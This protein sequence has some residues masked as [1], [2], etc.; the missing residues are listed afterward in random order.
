MVEINVSL[1]GGY[2]KY[3]LDKNIFMPYLY[4][5]DNRHL[6]AQPHRRRPGG[7][8]GQAEKGRVPGGPGQA[9][10]PGLPRNVPDRLPAP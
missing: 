2:V 9:R 1:G 10:A 6:P 4:L 8:P 3:K 5:Y 7:Q